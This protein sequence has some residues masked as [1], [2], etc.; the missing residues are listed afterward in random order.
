MSTP[1]FPDLI[2][3]L[4]YMANGNK[5]RDGIKIAKNRRVILDLPGE[6]GVIIRV[7]KYRK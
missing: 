3:M 2:N 4:Y 1:E 7:L 5:V 6:P